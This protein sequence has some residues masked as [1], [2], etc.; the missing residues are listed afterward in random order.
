MPSARQFAVAVGAVLVAAVPASAQDVDKSQYNLFNPTPR[1]LWRPLSADRP[2]ITESPITVDAA[3]VQLET[4]FFVYAH[5]SANDNA[6]TTNSLALAFSNIKFGL[7]NNADLQIIFAPYVREESRADGSGRTT[8]DDGPSDLFL[9]LK[10]NFWGNDGGPTALGVLPFIKIPTG[11]QVSNDHVEGGVALAFA[12]DITEGVGLGVNLGLDILYSE[13]TGDHDF[14]SL[15]SAALGFDIYRSVGGYVEYVG[16]AFFDGSDYE[17]FASF[18]L[19]YELTENAVLDGGALIG[20]TRAATDVAV[21]A[22]I[23][24][25]F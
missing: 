22:G 8:I 11:S 6:E 10:V 13:D 20:L 7:L 25:R 9:R 23:T 21:F 4:S 19:T 5:D 12:W 24:L 14:G 3:A 16:I 17:A 1:D 15:H 2:D 18:G